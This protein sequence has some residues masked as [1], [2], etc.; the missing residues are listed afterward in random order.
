M[1]Y[2][3]YNNDLC[4]AYEK[5]IWPCRRR[6]A[7]VNKASDT[8]QMA[9]RL[10]RN[11]LRYIEP[12]LNESYPQKSQNMKRILLDF[13]QFLPRN[14][15]R[16]RFSSSPLKLA[17]QQSP[18]YLL[19]QRTGLAYNLCREALNK[20]DNDLNQAESW[21]KAQEL[22]HGLKKATKVRG[23]SAHEGLIGLAIHRQN[24]L[25]TVIELNCETDFVAKNKIFQDFALDLT[26]QISST[27]RHSTEIATTQEHMNLLKPPENC[28]L[29]TENQIAP[30]IS[31]LGE[32]IKLKRA[33]HF[34]TVEADTI[35][36]GQAHAKAGEISDDEF[37]I[38][39]GRFGAIVTLRDHAPGERSIDKV[40][41]FGDRLCQHIIGFSPTY[42]ELPDN[43]RKHLEEIENE[44]RIREENAAHDAD[45]AD[46]SDSE[47]NENPHNNRDDWPSIMDQTLIMSEDTTVREFCK[48]M[49]LG[50]V[51][52]ERFECG[53]SP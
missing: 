19:R 4:F 7:A 51:Y 10:H 25:I 3:N 46:H 53:S 45:N 48:S 36:T 39:A 50:I 16:R 41:M 2:S 35:I 40:R 12:D 14:F 22:S 52:F 29:S 30:L 24:K 13:N 23:R 8:F 42:I 28:F 43:I 31:K 5:T 15:L 44:D 21:L 33:V 34:M 6:V 26:R 47:D 37:N 38:V 20:H 32:N 11:W 9:T 1:D 49:K 17:N 27:W 18:L